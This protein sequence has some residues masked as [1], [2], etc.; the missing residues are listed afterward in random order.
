MTDIANI[1]SLALAAETVT[2]VSLHRVNADNATVGTAFEPV[3]NLDAAPTRL[4]SAGDGI[5]IDGAHA[6][7]TSAGVGG[8]EVTVKGLDTNFAIKESTI[9]TSGTTPVENGVGAW[10]FVNEMYVSSVGTNLRTTGIL[11]LLDDAAGGSLGQIDAGQVNMQNCMW[12]VPAGHT[13]YIH[14][15]WYNV[16]GVAAPVGGVRFQLQLSQHGLQ[17]VVNSETWEALAEVY[18]D[19]PDDAIAVN[20]STKSPGQQYFMFPGGPVVIPAKSLVQ[21]AALATSTGAS[22]TGGFNIAIQGSGSG[23][24]ITESV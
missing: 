1:Q 23:T 3:T 16:L 13:G 10:T 19:E 24:T 4:A 14:G 15:F 9:A 7:D 6:E 8:R 22:V 2:N 5:E 17:G 12:K 20:E 21:L 18:M 11:T